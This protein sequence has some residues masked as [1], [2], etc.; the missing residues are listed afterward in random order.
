MCPNASVFAQKFKGGFK[1]IFLRANNRGHYSEDE[2][3]SN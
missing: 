3:K 2:S 1:L